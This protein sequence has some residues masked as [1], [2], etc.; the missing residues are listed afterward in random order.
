[1]AIIPDPQAKF[2]FVVNQS[3]NSVSE[4]TSNSNGTL[5]TSGNTVQLSV[6]PRWFSITN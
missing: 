3:A 1:V 4:F 2:T 6:A 5:S